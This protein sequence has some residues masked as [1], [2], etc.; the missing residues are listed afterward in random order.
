MA[1]VAKGNFKNIRVFISY[2]IEKKVDNTVYVYKK[3]TDC[4][5][6]ICNNL[7][8][9]KEVL[10]EIGFNIIKINQHFLELHKI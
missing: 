6:V 3:D 5:K 4:F 7:L 2:M 10:K 8:K 9:A 1:Y